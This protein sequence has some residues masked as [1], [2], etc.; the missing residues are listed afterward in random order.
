MNDPVYARAERAQPIFDQRMQAIKDGGTSGYGGDLAG[1][2]HSLKSQESYETKDARLAEEGRE[3]N[4]LNRYTFT[5]PPEHYSQGV[6]EKYQQLRDDGFAPIEGTHSDTWQDPSYKGL[7][8]S[9][10]DN[11]EDSPTYGQPVEVQFHTPD[12]FQAKEDNHGLYELGQDRPGARTA[13]RDY[14]KAEYKEATRHLQAERYQN[15]QQPENLESLHRAEPGIEQRSKQLGDCSEEVKETVRQDERALNER[16]SQARAESPSA[17]SPSAQSP[18]AQSPSAQSPSAQ[19]PSAESPRAESPSAESPS[20]E[21]PSAQSPSAQSPSAQSP[22][23]ALD[24]QV[25]ESNQ[26]GDSATSTPSPDSETSRG[27]QR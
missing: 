22:S 11:N 6:Q 1:L 14:D 8:T 2:D 7:N 25:D 17:E 13:E 10:R 9:W 20:A 21:S 5:F 26:A 19:S 3:P 18:S 27:A 4:D 15:V 16:Q 12:S 23:S 24:R